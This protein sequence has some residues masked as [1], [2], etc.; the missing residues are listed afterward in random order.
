MTQ[1][2]LV[3][4]GTYMYTKK[5]KAKQDIIHSVTVASVHHT[6]QE[7]GKQDVW[8]SRTRFWEETKKS[9]G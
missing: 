2:K 3:L 1:R 4:P 9:T 6:L 7:M 8:P 5:E